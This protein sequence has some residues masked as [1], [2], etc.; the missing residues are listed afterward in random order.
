LLGNGTIFGKMVMGTSYE[1][2]LV[3]ILPPG[4]FIT[5]G[6]LM[7]LFSWIEKNR[8]ANK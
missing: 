5:L 8:K 6:V 2:V 4:A 7:G 3:L 1:P